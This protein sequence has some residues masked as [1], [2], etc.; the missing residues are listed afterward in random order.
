LT[1]LLVSVKKTDGL[2]PLNTFGFIVPV[3]AVRENEPAIASILKA[4]GGC[5]AQ[6]PS[7][8]K[9]R[10]ANQEARK[11][12][13]MRKGW[14]QEHKLVLFHKQQAVLEKLMEVYKIMSENLPALCKYINL[15]R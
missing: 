5:S 10:A 7:L 14:R 3:D 12:A 6:D 13:L 1:P 8:E 9:A 11:E 4:R 15:L 2:L